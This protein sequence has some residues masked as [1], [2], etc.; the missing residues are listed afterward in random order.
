MRTQAA[1]Q[2]VE[3]VRFTYVNTGEVILHTALA[4]PEDGPPVIL[5]HGFPEFW[6]GWRHQIPYLAE[7]GFRV[8][9]PDQRGY[10][11]S[12][13]PGG[14]AAAETARLAGDVAGLAKAL[15]ISR[16]CLA[17]HDW[18][19]MVAWWTAAAYPDMVEKLAVMDV[20]HPA[21]FV[22]FL[23]K[24]PEQLLRSW[25]VYLFQVP[26]LPERALTARGCAALR[27]LLE[28]SALPGTFSGEDFARYRAAWTR[29]GSMRAMVNWYR[30]ARRWLFLPV[31]SLRV[32]A[33]TLMIHGKKDLFVSHRMCEPS[34]TFCDA[35]T[36]L[37]LF[38][39]NTHWVQHEKPGRVGGLLAQW[40]LGAAA[41]KSF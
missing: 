38:E 4:G 34:L 17:G 12:D 21:V 23:K 11:L 2:A 35:E 10:N 32:A 26:R 1:E 20:P 19:A 9:T 28:K 3:G 7:R 13:K 36:R 22:R 37:E 30:F 8:I 33:P 24:S 16:F 18:G 14:I 39:T 41:K 29:P 25:Y 27:F 15:G 5:L 6:Y 40:F 31:E